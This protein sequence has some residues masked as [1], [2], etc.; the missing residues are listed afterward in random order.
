MTHTDQE[1][2]NLDRSVYATAIRYKAHNNAKWYRNE[3]PAQAILPLQKTN[4]NNAICAPVICP[5]PPLLQSIHV[6]TPQEATPY[7]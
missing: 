1:K 6:V 7:M 4:T 2:E 3:F 5:F